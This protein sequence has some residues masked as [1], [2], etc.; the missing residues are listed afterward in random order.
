MSALAKTRLTV[1]ILGLGVIALPSTSS[2]AARASDRPHAS[3]KHASRIVGLFADWVIASGDSHGLP[4]VIVDKK[5]AEVLVFYPDGRLRGAAPTLLGLA[6]GDDSVP[7]IGQRKLSRITPAERTTPAGRFVASLGNDLGKKNVV[8][9]DYDDAIS[10]HRVITTNPKEHRLQRL[11]TLSILDNR[12]SY[13][14]INVP[15][16]FYDTVVEPS[17]TGTNGIV[18]ILPEV[19][20]IR[21]VFPTYEADK[22]VQN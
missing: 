2:A 5:N 13:G 10:L 16:K 8:W 9:V 12:I 18:Y 22:Q 6:R 7:G 11:A 15:V 19:R 3:A 1:L 21:D 17:F 14:C 4:F 20:S